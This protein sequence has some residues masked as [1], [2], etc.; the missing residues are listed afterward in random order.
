M[1]RNFITSKIYM[2]LKYS[3]Q[4]D[5]QLGGTAPA[6]NGQELVSIPSNKKKG[7]RENKSMKE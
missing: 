4:A 3:N 7:E 5:V 6:Y 1:Q 2:G